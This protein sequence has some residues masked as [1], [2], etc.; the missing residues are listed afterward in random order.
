MEYSKKIFTAISWNKMTSNDFIIGKDSFS[1]LEINPTEEKENFYYFSDKKS[2]KL[3]KQFILDERQQVNYICRVILIKKGEK[4]TPRLSLSVR[5]K[6]KKIIETPE[7]KPTDI[8]AN[9]NLNDCQENFWQL[10]SFLQSLKEIELP[11]GKF[12]LM[13][14]SESEIVAA[15]SGRDHKS[16]INIAKQILSS[17]GASLTQ[18]DINSLLKRKE[19]L[20]EFRRGLS[21]KIKDEGWWQNLFDLNKWIF[22]YGLNYEI[23]RNQQSQPNY[24]G[25]TIKGTGGQRGDNLM[26][27]MGDLSFTVLVEIKT[28]FTALLQGSKEI[29]NGAWSLSKELIDAISQIQT[30]IHTWESQGSKQQDNVDI[31]EKDKIFTVKPRGIIVIGSLG[32]FGT[33]RHKRET[34][35]R[36]RMSI[37]GIDILTFDELLRRAEFIVDNGEE[38]NEEEDFDVKDIPF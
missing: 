5:D 1:D 21:E 7:S 8:K 24:G 2:K 15:L 25:T 16:I 13:S 6:T 28:P 9:I 18:S 26:C 11:D 32:E 19:R 29:R 22:G 27:T 4:F 36:F 30:N 37:H 38:S 12:S 31:L 33:N 34:F 3:I 10:V 23:L 20:E 14:K 17:S 35:Q